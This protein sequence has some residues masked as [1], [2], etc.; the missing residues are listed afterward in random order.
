MLHE[1]IHARLAEIGVVCEKYAVQKLYA[2]G[3]VV[4]G[5]FVEGKSDIDLFV[6]FHPIGTA[7][8]N[9]SLVNLWFD[10]EAL[11]SCEVDLVTPESAKGAFFIK[12]LELYKVLIFED[13]K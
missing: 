5:R 4:D 13:C 2:F 3:S 11:L 6:E 9:Q 10:L 12:Y 7:E 1:S 8:K